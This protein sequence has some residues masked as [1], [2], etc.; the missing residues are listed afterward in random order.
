MLSSRTISM[1]YLFVYFS[2]N[3]YL[4]F[5]VEQRVFA[6]VGLLAVVVGINEIVCRSPYDNDYGHPSH[7][8]AIAL[9]ILAALATEDGLKKY[10]FTH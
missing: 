5:H 1:I 4:I 9:T 10:A 3:L 6:E 2:V 8:A 7:W